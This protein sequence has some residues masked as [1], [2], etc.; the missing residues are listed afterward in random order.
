MIYMRLTAGLNLCGVLP[1]EAAERQCL[2]A[3][4]S[5]S[6]CLSF[7]GENGVF[8]CLRWCDSCPSSAYTS[9]AFTWK[10]QA[11][12]KTCQGNFGQFFQTP[13]TKF[14]S[15]KCIIIFHLNHLPAA[16]C[17][18]WFHQLYLKCGKFNA[19]VLFWVDFSPR[20]FLWRTLLLRGGAYSG[21]TWWCW[22][23]EPCQTWV[24]EK[25]FSI[26]SASAGAL[27]AIVLCYMLC[28]IHCVILVTHDNC[29]DINAN[30][31][32]I[33]Q[34]HHNV[35]LVS[36]WQSGTPVCRMFLGGFVTVQWKE[37]PIPSFLRIYLE[38]R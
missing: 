19:E 32:Q 24:I 17:S 25:F 35:G 15:T 3:S 31:D 14:M 37:N 33:H 13:H 6:Q 36:I 7:W 22:G 16:L 18:H 2:S 11:C 23:T 12:Q 8:A 20:S 27:Y 38:K 10:K 26:I 29:C 28:Y 1:G 34:I 21:C 30:Q 4:A 9:P 5:Q